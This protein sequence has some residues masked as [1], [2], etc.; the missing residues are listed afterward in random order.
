MVGD[1]EMVY[2][3]GFFNISFEE[4]SH[5]NYVDLGGQARLDKTK[6]PV[7]FR[8]LIRTVNNTCVINAKKVKYYKDHCNVHMYCSHEGCKLFRIKI[9]PANG[10]YKAI[11]Y[12]SGLNYHHNPVDNGLTNHVKGIQRDLNKEALKKTKAFSFWSDAVNMVSPT[13]LNCGNLQG[14][15]SDDVVRKHD[16]YVSCDIQLSIVVVSI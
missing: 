5:V 12:S 16:I 9:Q 15:K 6:Y 10:T 4:W 1:N 13:Q 14:I 3:E 8:K 7:M 11:V 2:R